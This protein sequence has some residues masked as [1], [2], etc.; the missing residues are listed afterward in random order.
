MGLL[1]GM[2][3]SSGGDDTVVRERLETLVSAI[4]QSP[5]FQL[6]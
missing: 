3:I 4:I 1:N 6:L 2:P 5:E